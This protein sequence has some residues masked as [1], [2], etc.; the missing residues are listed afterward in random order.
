[1]TTRPGITTRPLVSLDIHLGPDDLNQAL[2]ADARRGLTAQPKELSPMWF[3]D[4]AGSAL[5]EEITALE[6]YY[7]TRRER[8]ILEA[9]AG[10]IAA[11]TGAD[12]LVEL[13]SGSSAKTRLLL[14]ALDATGRLTRFVP[15]DICEAA[16]RSAAEA[17]A[18]EYRGLNVHAVVGNFEQ[19]LGRLPAGGRRMV[20]FLGSTIGNLNP[21]KRARLL[22][23]LAQ[24]MVPGDSLLLG[25]DLLKDPAR[26]EAAYNDKVGVTAA[27][28]LN[29][30]SVL[31]RELDANFDPGRFAHVARFYPEN[32]WIEMRLRSCVDQT[33]TVAGLGLD[34]AFARDEEMRTEIS[35]KFSPASMA[36]ELGAAGLELKHLWTD[37]AADFGLFLAFR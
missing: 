18:V 6:E 21:A 35:T 17:V 36:A 28:N 30:L 34:V 29:V 4:E 19:H 3:Y 33:V 24:G 10:E 27:F 7:P 26:L 11:L 13:G 23:E 15:F 31:N 37:R 16:L 20:A 14:D 1:M 2:R 32:Q 12:T 22:G 9:H 5:F 8:E 25:C